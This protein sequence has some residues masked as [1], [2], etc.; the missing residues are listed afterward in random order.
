MK[1]EK[2]IHKKVVMNFLEGIM[3]TAS[4]DKNDEANV[5]IDLLLIVLRNLPDD[6][7]QKSMDNIANE[8]KVNSPKIFHEDDL[9]F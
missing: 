9:P 2:F 6:F 1:K 8:Y 5:A 4:M 3:R 7:L